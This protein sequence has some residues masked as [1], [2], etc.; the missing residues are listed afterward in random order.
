[1][2]EVAQ[3]LI[4]VKEISNTIELIYGWAPEMKRWFERLLGGKELKKLLFMEKTQALKKVFI[5]LIMMRMKIHW[6]RLFLPQGQ[7]Q[8]PHQK[9]FIQ[10]SLVMFGI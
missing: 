6:L 10:C 4:P 2:I 8:K 5:W 9:K 1:M 3:L 7:S